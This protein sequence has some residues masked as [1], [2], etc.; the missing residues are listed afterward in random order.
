MLG[1]RDGVSFLGG[2]GN[3][4]SA[5]ALSGVTHKEIMDAMDQ[6]YLDPANA[7]IP[8][9]FAMT[10]V[11]WKMRGDTETEFQKNIAN[12]RKQWID[13][14]ERKIFKPPPPAPK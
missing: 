5:A 11:A 8:M 9:Y 4:R 14:V 6:L 12:A 10:L 1:Y 2:G 3:K 7:R 13:V